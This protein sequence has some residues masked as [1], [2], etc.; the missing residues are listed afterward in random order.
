[1]RW[2][3]TLPL[4][5]LAACA[6]VE[7]STIAYDP[8]H[9]AG[10]LDVHAPTGATAAP[11]VLLVHGGSWEG[12]ERGNMGWTADRL[13]GLGYVAATADYRLVPEG[14]FPNAVHDT[15]CALAYLRVHAAELGIDPARIAALG[16]SAGGH[17]V[18]LMGVAADIAELQS[19]ACP[20]GRV[21]RPAAVISFAGPT[22][23]TALDADV[24]RSFVGVAL[25]ADRAR[26]ELAS[27][28]FHVDPG[29][30]PFLLVHSEH[31]LVAPV[32]QSKIMVT[33]LRG[34]GNQPEYLQLEGGGHLLGD[35]AGLGIEQSEKP[36]EATESWLALVDFLDRTIGAP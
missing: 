5:G 10:L 8:A 12:G 4:A 34:A 28:A 23:L 29:E 17:L 16:Y 19:D 20:S 14:E 31:D 21:E 33:R 2:S 7:V 9:S 32:E 13:A 22:D 1:M 6:D 3:L 26:W 36:Y 24:T 18:S 30:P 25:D 27:P 35:G 11:A 15:F